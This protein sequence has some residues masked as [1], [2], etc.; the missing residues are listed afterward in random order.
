VNDQPVYVK[1]FDELGIENVAEVGGE[2]SSLGELDRKL[3]PLGVRIP[4][5]FAVTADSYRDTLTAEGAWDALAEVLEGSDG[6]DV[7]DLAVRARQARE[8]VYGSRAVVSHVSSDRSA[9]DV[10]PISNTTVP[11]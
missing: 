3:T 2:N 11:S 4:N 5:G 6:T 1:W 8:T 7:A 10:R 9:P